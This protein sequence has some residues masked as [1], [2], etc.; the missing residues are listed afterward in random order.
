[1][2]DQQNG[3]EILEKFRL[4]GFAGALEDKG[5]KA[6]IRI[7]RGSPYVL[8]YASP[9]V[10]EGLPVNEC[11]YPVYCDRANLHLVT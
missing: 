2:K 1:M 7:F 8:V 10:V 5:I 9:A 3:G 4:S 11:P 6:G